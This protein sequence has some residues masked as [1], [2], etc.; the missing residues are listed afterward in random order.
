M[1][2]FLAAAGVSF[3]MNERWFFAPDR[4]G[5]TVRD[6]STKRA[7]PAVRGDRSSGVGM[8]MLHEPS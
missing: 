3:R 5:R 4:A 6:S 7:A 8:V 1:L 2:L